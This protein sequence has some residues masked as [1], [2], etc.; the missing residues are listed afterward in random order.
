MTTSPTGWIDDVAEADL[1]AA[2]D[3]LGRAI[4]DA[5]TV[6][7]AAHVA[8]DGDALGAT[9]ALHAALAARGVRTIPTVGEAPLRIPAPL[10][11]LPH[12]GDLAEPGALPAP[13][14]VTLLVTLDAASPQ[15]LGTVAGLIDAGVPTLVVDHHERHT[16]FG[17]VQ[18]VA[19]RAAATVMVVDELLRRLDLPLTRDVATCLYVGLI[20]DTGRFGHASTD[21][22]AMELAGRLLD[23]GVDQASITQRLF[24][25]RS[26]AELRLLGRALERLEFV[27]GVALVHTH[28]VD[29]DLAEL[30]SGPEATEA[31]VDVVRTT[32]VAEV[33]LMLKPGA[34]GRWR[35][36]LR[37]H[38]ATDVGA[39]AARFGGGGHALAA[40]F[41]ADGA[42][43]EVVAEV[44]AALSEP[45]PAADGGDP[46]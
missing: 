17:D 15:R 42:L 2:T 4:R 24:G 6:V 8:P 39:V 5:G 43:D 13:E 45:E 26:L 10:A 40:G 1:D 30:G 41:T 44:V 29:E 46:R 38:G 3:L 34:D 18:L 27:P 9:L 7:L 23:A 20:T 25:N 19:P 22:A 11:D 32:D 33:S 36:S 35:A 12:V 14:E 31:I 28:L 16:P 37:S 21:R